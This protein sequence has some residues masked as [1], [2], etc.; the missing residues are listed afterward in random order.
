M[1][2]LAAGS[3]LPGHVRA[4]LV[5]ATL[6]LDSTP[7]PGVAGAHYIGSLEQ[8]GNVL[9]LATDAGPLVV[10]AKFAHTAA[11]LLSDIKS[12]V[13]APPALLINT[14]HHADHSGGNWIFKSPENRAQ[15]IA[16]KNHKPRLAGNL[17]RYAGQAEGHVEELKK[18]S[19]DQ[20]RVKVAEAT[21]VKIKSLKADSFAATKEVADGATVI[22]HGGLRIELYHYGPGHTDND[23]VVFIPKHNILHMGDLLFH[24]V[25]PFIDRGAKANTRGWQNSVREAMK[26]GDDKTIVIPG[27]GALTDKRALPKQI[28]YF[29]Q[30]RLIVET[31]IREGESKEAVTQM[32]PEVFRGRGFEMLRGMALGA[33]YDEVS[34]GMN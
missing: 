11:D 7:I 15:I 9:A 20:A 32:K 17:E 13:S 26:L 12:L 33:M 23:L 24:E 2:A 22:D 4:A 3:A 25:H 31:A 18:E 8:G 14:H 5:R 30:L 34:E 29:D 27:H 28:D 10:D 1:A 21:L 19:A 16:H 6:N